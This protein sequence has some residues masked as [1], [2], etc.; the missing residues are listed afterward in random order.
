MPLPPLLTSLSA[1][2][3]SIS[4]R[5]KRRAKAPTVYE[6]NSLQDEDHDRK[7]AGHMD[8][9]EIDDLVLSPSK[10][11]QN[12]SR[13]AKAKSSRGITESTLPKTI[14]KVD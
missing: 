5:V 6:D 8:I 9:D 7:N 11:R 3:T 2:C 12:V 1:D 14:D 13:A 4:S 10:S